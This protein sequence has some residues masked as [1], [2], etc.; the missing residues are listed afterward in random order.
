MAMS[1]RTPEK[2]RF[3]QANTVTPIQMHAD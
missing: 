3:R 2:E 1:L